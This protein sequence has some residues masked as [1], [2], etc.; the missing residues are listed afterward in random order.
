LLFPNLY[1]MLFWEFVLFQ[2]LYMPKPT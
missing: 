2:S 1:I